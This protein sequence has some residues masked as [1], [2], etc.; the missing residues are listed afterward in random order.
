[1]GTVGANKTTIKKYIQEQ[2]TEDRILDKRSMKEY[3]NPFTGKQEGL[4]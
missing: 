3:K 2:E 4:G 1:M